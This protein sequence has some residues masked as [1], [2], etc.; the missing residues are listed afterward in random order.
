MADAYPEVTQAAPERAW[1]ALAQWAAALVGTWLVLASFTALVDPY[2]FTGAPRVPGWTERKYEMA[3]FGRVA[4]LREVARLKP[5]AIVLGNSQAEGGLRTATLERLTGLGAYNLGFLGARI[6]ETAVAFEHA[7]RVAPVRTAVLALDYVAFEPA[8]E[9]AALLRARAERRIGREARDLADLTFSMQGFLAAVRGVTLNR[10]GGVPT[11]DGRGNWSA[12][13]PVAIDDAA[14][15]VATV[16]PADGAY[17]AFEA[18]C[19]AAA[20]RGVDLRLVVMPVH[21]AFGLDM[22]MRARWVARLAAIAQSHGFTLHD[23]GGDLA[24]NADKSHFIDRGHVS[25]AIGDVILDRLFG[26][27][28]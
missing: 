1:P 8:E 12:R 24:F 4:K 27:A 22:E 10:M 2:A 7:L 26:A 18:I 15:P 13:Q 25:V 6:E 20:E 3:E 16:P 23:E 17:A 21:K 9:R 14:V 28:R 5:T 11:H 19:R